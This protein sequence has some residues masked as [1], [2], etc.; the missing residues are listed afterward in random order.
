MATTALVLAGLRP[1]SQLT[2]WPIRTGGLDLPPG[3]GRGGVPARAGGTA[4]SPC[5]SH[6]E[7]GAEFLLKHLFYFVS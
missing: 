2:C 4:A 5:P 6:Q 1:W 3:W 7:A